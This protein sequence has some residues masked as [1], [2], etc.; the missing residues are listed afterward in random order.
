MIAHFLSAFNEQLES[1]VQ[2]GEREKKRRLSLQETE[3]KKKNMCEY[4]KG[5]EKL[6]SFF[7]FIPRGNSLLISLYF[8]TVSLFF[9]SFVLAM[10]FYYYEY[11]SVRAVRDQRWGLHL[12][13][14]RFLLGVFDCLF[15]IYALSPSWTLGVYTVLIMCFFS[16]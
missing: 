11:R 9:T 12:F 7:I 1:K 6:T 13:S 10:S 14:L 16:G 15:L 2:S 5:R 4:E 3:D 8:Y